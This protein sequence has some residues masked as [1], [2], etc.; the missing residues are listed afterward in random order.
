MNVDSR[1][2][3]ASEFPS[4]RRTAVVIA[5]RDRPAD[6][7]RTLGNLRRSAGA[8]EI[9]VV[10]N[11]STGEVLDPLA[12][13]YPDVLFLRLRQN[14]GCGA[15]TIG[16]RHATRP[17]VAFSDDDSWWHPGSLGQAEQLFDH[18]PRLGAIAATVLVG[19]EEYPDPVVDRM[20]NGLSADPSLPGRPVLGFLAC[21]VV[22]RREAFLEAGGFEARYGMGGEERLL[23]LDIVRNGWGLVWAEQVVAH[24]YPSVTS[25][26]HDGR[27]LAE[28]RNGVWTAWLRRPLRIAIGETL[29]LGSGCSDPLVRR[30]LVDAAR[31]LP[32]VL[33]ARQRVPDYLEDQLAELRRA[34]PNMGPRGK[35]SFR[36]RNDVVADASGI[37]SE[38]E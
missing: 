28:L 26:D 33:R 15:R 36:E 1:H 19:K 18:Y 27:R 25:R 13:E 17:F 37:P 3:G 7:R 2:P 16:V 11:A 5:T 4:A 34:E 9:I 14:V 23:A 32:W 10:D 29:R 21:G 6:L 8:A 35:P 20:R 24:H 22:V 30:A 31:G 12:R 38:R